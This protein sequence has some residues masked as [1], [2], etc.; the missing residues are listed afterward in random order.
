MLYDQMA[1]TPSDEETAS[2]KKKGKKMKMRSRLMTSSRLSKE[3]DT[4]L[5]E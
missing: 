1:V 3:E 5:K 2:N 4:D